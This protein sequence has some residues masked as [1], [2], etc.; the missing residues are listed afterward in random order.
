MRLAVSEPP[1]GGQ[2][3]Q[4]VPPG[5]LVLVADLGLQQVFKRGLVDAEVLL[6]PTADLADSPTLQASLLSIVGPRSEADML[7]AESALATASLA[8][9]D[10]CRYRPPRTW[11]HLDGGTC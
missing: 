8:G 6:V 10:A 5:I 4:V 11:M 3:V 9:A 1:D 2:G 7:I